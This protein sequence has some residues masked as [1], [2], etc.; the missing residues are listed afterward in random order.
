MDVPQVIPSFDWF[1]IYEWNDHSFTIIILFHGKIL[2]STRSKKHSILMFSLYI[3]YLLLSH[4]S[5]SAYPLTFLFGFHSILSC[6]TF[7]LK[8]NTVFLL[9]FSTLYCTS[10]LLLSLSFMSLRYLTYFLSHLSPIEFLSIVSYS[11]LLTF[12]QLLLSFSLSTS[13]FNIS[14]PISI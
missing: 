13:D 1:I 9:H 4:F 3:L 10:S 6:S 5:F 11:N 7:Y 12:S 8:I 14:S 2:I